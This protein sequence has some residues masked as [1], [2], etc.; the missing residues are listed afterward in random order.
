MSTPQASFE[1]DRAYGV[2]H[3]STPSE[4]IITTISRPDWLSFR[5]SLEN[6][7][8]YGEAGNFILSPELVTS[9][10]IPLGEIAVKRTLIQERVHE[11]KLLTVNHPSS[12]L[13]LGTAVF[14]A[15]GTRAR[16]AVLFLRDGTEIGRTH[17]VHTEVRAE[18]EVF[19]RPNVPDVRKPA[20]H[21]AAIISAD[22]IDP[23]RTVD[24]AGTL[25]ISSCW[26]V[27]IGHPD[28]APSTEPRLKDGL[29]MFTQELFDNNP[30]L[31][32]VVMADRV[33]EVSQAVAPFNFVATRDGGGGLI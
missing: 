22:L 6:I 1:F 12:T 11:A 13:L 17:K 3:I 4:D 5:D 28:S 21:I 31:N 8:S 7:T 20:P 14:N 24:S 18:Q 2:R 15:E 27:P 29:T 19:Y 33:P 16:N 30:Q 25:L 10:D 26:S 9:T 23:P 32:T